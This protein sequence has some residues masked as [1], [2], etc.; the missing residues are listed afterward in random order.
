MEHMQGKFRV[1]ARDRFRSLPLTAIFCLLLL[2]VQGA[3]L[4]HSHDNDLHVRYDCDICLRIGSSID[5]IAAV[6]VDSPVSPVQLEWLD[7]AAEAPYQ[8]LF[9]IRSRAPP[10]TR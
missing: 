1:A 10:Q 8:P 5:V 2:F 4:S 9:D 3:A 7:A 6:H